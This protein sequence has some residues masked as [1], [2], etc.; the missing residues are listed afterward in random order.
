MTAL[1]VVPVESSVRVVGW[2]ELLEGYG[3]AASRDGLRTSTIAVHLAH[4]RDLARRTGTYPFELTAKNIVQWL[5]RPGWA[6]ATRKAHRSSVAA[7]F[8][9]GV[10]VGLLE[11]NP[12]KDVFASQ[13][14]SVG[15]AGGELVYDVV[16]DPA[17]SEHHARLWARRAGAPHAPAGRLPR[18]VLEAWVAAGSPR[19]EVAGRSAAAAWSRLLDDYELAARAAGKRP[20]TIAARRFHCEHLA[21][22]T[23]VAPEELEPSDLIE[24]QGREGLAPATRRAIRGTFRAVFG[25][26]HESGR[27]AADPAAQLPAVRVPG[28]VPRPAP[29]TVIRDAVNRAS[30]KQRLMLLLAAYEGLRRAEIARLRVEDL[31]PG[32]WHIT[33]KGGRERL[34][35]MHAAMV[36][37]LE[38]YLSFSGILT[39]WIFPNT[40][41]T[42]H[43]SAE[44]IGRT[45]SRLLPPGV[46]LHKLRHR[47]ASLAYAAAYDIRSVQEL[48]GHS[49]PAVTARYIAVP[50][51][52]LEA[53]VH[54]VPPVPGIAPARQAR[55]SGI[56]VTPHQEGT[57]SACSTR[58]RP[59][60][61]TS[62]S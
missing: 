45:T 23:G 9:W 49:S 20:G 42:G 53:A 35:P 33:G 3:A 48:L 8:A 57:A 41:G 37:E 36:E 28:G 10:D 25:W 22:V 30:P 34:V 12:A 13:L 4:C 47:F 19:L 31:T 59:P 52:Q 32:G 1:R 58:P 44:H 39:G 43:L 24:W 38:A 60:K 2:D 21:R 56:Y 29:E 27:L 54:A 18:D 51:P 6:Y 61:T 55:M 11:V 26:A 40:G 50:T 5:A 16:R 17:A 7:V 62:R 15:A 14:S 46:S